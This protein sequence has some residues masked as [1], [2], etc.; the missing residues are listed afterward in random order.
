MNEDGFRGDMFITTRLIYLP[1]FAKNVQG[2][3][4]IAAEI[5]YF[6]KEIGKVLLQN[7][8]SG[9]PHFSF[10]AISSVKDIMAQYEAEDY[11]WVMV[12]TE[13]HPYEMPLLLAK[14]DGEYNVLDYAGIVEYNSDPTLYSTHDYVE[15]KE[16]LDD[17]IKRV[18]KWFYLY[19]TIFV[20]ATPIVC[21]SSFALYIA[22]RRRR[23]ETVRDEVDNNSN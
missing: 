8:L 2:E 16:A 1:I 19:P 20:I 22:L 9:T 13:H 17:S 7:E 18:N 14:A 10:T 6:S 3:E 21:V 15:K 23:K 5:M 11:V 12:S 4:M